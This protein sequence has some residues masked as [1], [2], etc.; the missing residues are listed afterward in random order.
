MFHVLWF[1]Y[2][3]ELDMNPSHNKSPLRK[4][5]MKQRNALVIFMIILC[6]G[7][8]YKGI[9]QNILKER[10][11][12]ILMIGKYATN[13]LFQA[14]HAGARMA[15]KEFGIQNNVEIVIDWKTPQINS[16]K[17][18]LSTINRSIGAGVDGIAIACSEARLLTPALNKAVYQGIPVVCFISDAPES[19]RFAYYGVD[20]VEFGRSIVK[21]LADQL[22]E[23]GTIAVL[24]G[25]KDALNHEIRVQAILD[26]L[27]NHPGISLSP[28]NIYHTQEI[29]DQ[30]IEIVQ[31]AQKKNPSIKG[32]AFLGSWVLL[33]KNS[34]PWSPGEVKVVA[35]YAMPEELEYIKSGHVQVLIGV[36]CF[37][38]GYKSVELLVDKILKNQEPASPMIYDPFVRIS[39]ENVGEWLIKWN[40]WLLKEAVNR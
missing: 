18:Q 5:I 13:P 4:N 1:S 25:P 6:C 32:W 29:A 8:Y 28:K 20:D 16:A 33:K 19:K 12:T 9:G 10:K 24:A 30:A 21:E 39:K 14:A 15:A 2:G 37:Q 22:E 17:E 31:R 40:K 36:N 11:I 35:A 3:N 27:K 23:K 38:S 7:T 34:L 26:E